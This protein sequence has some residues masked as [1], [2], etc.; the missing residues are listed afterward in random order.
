MNKIFSVLAVTMVF[1]ISCS[2][3]TPPETS[4]RPKPPDLPRTSPETRPHDIEQILYIPGVGKVEVELM[5]NELILTT[6]RKGHGGMRINLFSDYTRV[7]IQ[8]YIYD[9]IRVPLDDFKI[10]V[11]TITADNKVGTVTFQL[12]EGK[13]Y[14]W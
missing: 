9:V 11:I 10:Y 7:P 4:P 5:T 3:K 6:F 8:S 14:I 13:L 12:K 2:T 1:L